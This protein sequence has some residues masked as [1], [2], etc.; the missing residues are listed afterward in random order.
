MSTMRISPNTRHVASLA[1]GRDCLIS[2]DGRA[3][4]ARGHLTSWPVPDPRAIV[5]AP[6]PH[7]VCQLP[8]NDD[9]DDYWE[10]P[11]FIQVCPAHEA[12]DAM[13]KKSILYKDMATCW[14]KV[15]GYMTL[16]WKRFVHISWSPKMV[17]QDSR[18]ER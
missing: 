1:A 6:E 10:G 11:L 2:L 17:G 14:L 12:V 18:I 4:V 5:E 7:W 3:V 8:T 16:D 13:A 15:M 9:D